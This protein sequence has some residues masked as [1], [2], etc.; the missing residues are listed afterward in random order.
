[1]VCTIFH[2]AARVLLSPPHLPFRHFGKARSSGVLM[3]EM[4]R[5]AHHEAGHCSVGGCDT[6]P[7][8][9]VRIYSDEGAWGGAAEIPGAENANHISRGAVAVAGILAEARI[10]TPSFYAADV[11]IGALLFSRILNAIEVML[12]S[13]LPVYRLRIPMTLGRDTFDSPLVNLTREDV[14]YID[15]ELFDDK[16]NPDFCDAVRQAARHVN[17]GQNWSVIRGLANRLIKAAGK[18]IDDPFKFL[19]K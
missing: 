4:E 18:W 5:T 1:L 12:C 9:R 10:A 7:V 2:D 17:N 13:D 8:K 14:S 3:T 11:K 16:A 15:D 19:V 6:P